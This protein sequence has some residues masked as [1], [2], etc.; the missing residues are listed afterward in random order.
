LQNGKFLVEKRHTEDVDPGYAI[1][2]GHVEKDE[3][4]SAALQR[5]IMEELRLVIEDPFYL[6]TGDHVASD[7]ELQRIH[8]FVVRNWKGEPIVQ[9]AESIS[10]IDDSNILTYKVDRKAIEKLREILGLNTFRKL[11]VIYSVIVL[12]VVAE[13]PPCTELMCCVTSGFTIS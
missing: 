12:G 3:N 8:Y 9:E 5:E 4:L 11:N 1:P 6:W 7:G 13:R 2:G 10:W